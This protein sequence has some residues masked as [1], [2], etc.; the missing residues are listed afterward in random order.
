MMEK[1]L[2]ILGK[3]QFLGVKHS[4]YDVTDKHCIKAPPFLIYFKAKPKTVNDIIKN[5]RCIMKS[6]IHTKMVI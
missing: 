6:D 5:D 2:T 4:S 3:F 1:G